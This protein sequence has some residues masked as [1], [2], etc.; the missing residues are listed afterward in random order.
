MLVFLQTKAKREREGKKTTKMRKKK[1][2]NKKN[3]SHTEFKTKKGFF[4]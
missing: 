1:S 2:E 4:L 3:T